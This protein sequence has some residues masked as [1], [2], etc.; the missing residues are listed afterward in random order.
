MPMDSLTSFT[1]KD[2][3][4]ILVIAVFLYLIVK[5]I[6]GTRALQIIKGFAVLLIVMASSR[7]LGLHTVYW[8]L[9]YLLYGIVVALPIVLQ[10]ELRRA[11]GY[12]GRGGALRDAFSSSHVHDAKATM[13]SIDH[14]V[15]AVSSL[16]AS[17]T[18]ALIVLERDT[19]LDEYIETGTLINGDISSKLLISI[20]NTKSPLHD[21]AVVISKFRVVAASCYLPASENVVN[22]KN[23]KGYGT[24][25]RA[26]LG[27]AEQTDAVTIVVSEETGI[28]SVSRNAKLTP[29][30][31]EDTLKKYLVDLYKKDLSENGGYFGENLL[32]KGK[33]AKNAILDIFKRKSGT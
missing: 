13:Q 20:F 10:P 15:W 21:G 32:G 25:H 24:R 11:L 3:V 5:S 30:Y 28:I 9:Q 17:K 1:F 18:G 12:I 33:G 19:G 26:A 7:Y 6:Q 23:K 2:A 31:N 27:M 29:R 14:I 22:P 16:S 8:L 4:D